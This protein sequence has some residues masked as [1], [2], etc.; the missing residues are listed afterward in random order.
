V[1]PPESN[2]IARFAFDPLEPSP[3]GQHIGETKP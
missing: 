1:I 2:K 3:S